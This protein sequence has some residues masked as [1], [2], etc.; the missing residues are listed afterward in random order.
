MT[1]KHTDHRALNIFFCLNLDSALQGATESS[2]AF[3]EC[4]SQCILFIIMK[5]LKM[6]RQENPEQCK[7]SSFNWFVVVC[8]LFETCTYLN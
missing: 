6:P 7:R 4:H 5:M 8:A 2:N 3:G 1:N